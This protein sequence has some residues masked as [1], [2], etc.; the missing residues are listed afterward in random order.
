M[1]RA[2][3]DARTAAVEQAQ[4]DAAEA[5]EGTNPKALQGNKKVPFRTLPRA[6]L[7]PLAYVMKLGADKYGWWNWRKTKLQTGDYLEAVERHVAALYDGEDTDPESG[8]SHW[9]H[10]AATALVYLDAELCGMT[11]DDRPYPGPSAQ[12]IRDR[13]KA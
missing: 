10:I 12:L 8:E 4:S 3:I 5:P 7:I 13:K 1:S 9:A 6:A 11:E 2:E